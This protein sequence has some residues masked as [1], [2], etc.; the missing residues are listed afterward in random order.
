MPTFCR[1]NRLLHHCPICAREQEVELSPIITSSAP[2]TTAPRQQRPTERRAVT[3]GRRSGTSQASGV[4]VRQLERGADDGYRSS[5]APGLRSSVEAERLADEIAFGATRLRMLTTEPPGLYAEVAADGDVEERAWLAFLIAYLC[6]LDS[7][8]PFASIR[9]VRKPWANAEPLDLEAVETGPRSAHEP[10]SHA[11]TLDAYRAWARRA[12][13]QSEALTGNPEWS[14]ERRFGRVFERL[15][16]PGLHRGARFD[17]LVTLGALGVFELR[18]GELVLGGTEPVTVAA[19][20]VF[21]IGERALLERR[22]ATLAAACE[23]PLAAF[24]LG[25]YNWQRGERA[26]IGLAPGTEPDREALDAARA[27]LGL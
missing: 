14:A 17:L 4:R 27:A 19:K 1:H 21:G 16:L 13:T 5:L 3:P 25:L 15:A 6:P 9:A 12:G 10:A 18:P 26:A 11:R 2:H 23:L 24:D 20:R 8:D 7:A 22:A